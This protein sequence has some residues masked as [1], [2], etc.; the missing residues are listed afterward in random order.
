MQDRSLTGDDRADKEETMKTRDLMTTEVVTVA[1]ET[2]LKDVAAL[3]V[4]RRISGVP[5]VDEDRHVLGVISEA[6]ILV[7]EGGDG[8]REG[9]LGWLFEPDDGME[10]KLTATTAGDAMSS[11]PVTVGPEVP[12]HA[13]ATRMVG[14]GINRLPVVHEDRLVGIVSRADLVRAFARDD[15]EIAEEIQ[16]EVLQRTL[17]IEPGR[18]RVSVQGGAVEISGEVDTE[19]DAELLPLFVQRVPGV[20]S[21]QANL[22]AREKVRVR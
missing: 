8:R 11:P 1:P 7:R 16:S 22:S 18:V 21:V 17:W 9:L 20:V 13:A 2:S 3:L 12:I 14:A 5:V 19:T 4:E 6:D 15:A 10:R